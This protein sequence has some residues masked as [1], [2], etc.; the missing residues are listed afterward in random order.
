M[1]KTELISAVA[2]KA[3]LTKKQAD[4]AVAAVFESV[5]EE[6]KKG[7][8]VQLIG[9][10]TFAVKHREERTGRNPATNS[11]ITIP[12]ANVPTFKAGAALKDAVK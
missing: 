12:A 6:L 4:A 10:G 9:F 2:E 5:T 3:G 11:N 7:G 1:N 8:K